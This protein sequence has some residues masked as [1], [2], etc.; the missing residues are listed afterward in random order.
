M[1]FPVFANKEV[2][3]FYDLVRQWCHPDFPFL[4][5]NYS[6][7]SYMPAVDVTSF[8]AKCIAANK[9]S[10]ITEL[11][12]YLTPD[13]AGTRALLA[14]ALLK[15]LPDWLSLDAP[16]QAEVQAIYV[17]LV[18]M[19][20]TNINSSERTAGA[21]A[22]TTLASHQLVVSGECYD[23]LLRHTKTEAKAL[24]VDAKTSLQTAMSPLHSERPCAD[25]IKSV[26]P[27]ARLVVEDYVSRGWGVGKL[28]P[29]LYYGER[30]WQPRQSQQY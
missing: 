27:M 15:R 12:S 16:S 14:N 25:K 2:A 5:P 1:P 17:L 21:L 29:S 4:D 30:V 6:P 13:S 22:A 26:K 7:G 28:R 10:A 19:T 20:C 8:I 18:R 3:D 9:Y 23:T 11:L 24:E